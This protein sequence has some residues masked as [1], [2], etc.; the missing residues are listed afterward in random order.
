MATYLPLAR[1]EVVTLIVRVVGRAHARD[2]TWSREDIWKRMAVFLSHNT[3]RASR[4]VH[5]VQRLTAE[6]AAE[7][8]IESIGRKW[9]IE[10]DRPFPEGVER[11]FV[12]HGAMSEVVWKKTGSPYHT[13]VSN[14]S[15]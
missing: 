9:D 15:D 4:I 3:V 13:S 10:N 1:R 5:S 2:P 8:V 7:G 6:Q 11:V 14:S 12:P